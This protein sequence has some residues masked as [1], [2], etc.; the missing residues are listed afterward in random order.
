MHVGAPA[1]GDP[2]RR[3]TCLS[4]MRDGKSLRAL[5]YSISLAHQ[6]LGS[7]QPPARGQTSGPMPQPRPECAGSSSGGGALAR[8]R[9]PGSAARPYQG[10]PTDQTAV[11]AAALVLTLGLPTD[12]SLAWLCPKC[13][14]S[15]AGPA[16]TCRTPSLL[17]ATWLGSHPPVPSPWP[18]LGLTEHSLR[19][20]LLPP[21]TC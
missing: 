6:L 18:S 9:V 10:R 11:E 15:S 14:R 5:P 2:P 12:Q 17:M 8:R 3:V 1:T 19:I 13:R 7:H 16:L 4:P 20:P 21:L